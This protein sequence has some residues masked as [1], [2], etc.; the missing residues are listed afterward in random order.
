MN[1]ET[2]QRIQARIR[3]YFELFTKNATDPKNNRCIGCGAT[4]KLP[5]WMWYGE[6]DS[7]FI[8][9]TFKFRQAECCCE[10]MKAKLAEID[11]IRTDIIKMTAEERVSLMMSEAGVPTRYIDSSFSNFVEKGKSTG[12]L[13]VLKKYCNNMDENFKDGLGLYMHGKPGSGKTHLA[14]AVMREAIVRYPKDK[15]FIFGP[16]SYTLYRMKRTFEKE[17][18]C[19]D[20]DIIEKMVSADLVVIDDLGKEHDTPWVKSMAYM[21][22]NERYSEKMPTIFTTNV[23]HQT[24]VARYDESTV[25]RIVGSCI[26][27]DFNNIDDYRLEQAKK[28]K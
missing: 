1:Q 6:I 3:E 8:R 27:L 25:S 2:K 19:D 22:I 7:Y 26:I 23:E 14:A 10:T 15:C 20:R 5:Q 17:G 9:N 11:A 21:I 18:A 13:S 4:I 24:L 16:L 12:I 28:N